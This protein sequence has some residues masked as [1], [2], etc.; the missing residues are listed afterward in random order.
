MI[1]SERK[2]DMKKTRGLRWVSLIE[3]EKE[4]VTV[5]SGTS[6]EHIEGLCAFEVTELKFILETKSKVD[7]H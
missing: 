6:I 4:L 1:S 3:L 2:R 7:S 5:K